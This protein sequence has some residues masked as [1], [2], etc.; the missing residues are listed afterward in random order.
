MEESHKQNVEEARHKRDY[1]QHISLN[2][3]RKKAGKAFALE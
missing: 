1:T 3:E 2:R